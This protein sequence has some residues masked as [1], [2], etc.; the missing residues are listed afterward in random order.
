MLSLPLWA[1]AAYKDSKTRHC[2]NWVWFAIVAIELPVVA[3]HVYQGLSIVS[4]GLS[5]AF[6]SAFGLITYQL[7]MIGGADAKAFLVLGFAFPTL[8]FSIFV[9]TTVTTAV[10]A[11][12]NQEETMPFLVPLFAGILL[13]LLSR[14]LL[15]F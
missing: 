13:S 10:Y 9:Y 8:G 4:I 1:Y 11:I 5:V 3:Y 6:L 12:L 2:P 15:T 14:S 7:N